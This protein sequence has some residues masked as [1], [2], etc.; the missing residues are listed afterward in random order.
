MQMSPA[1]KLKVRHDN[2]LTND[3]SVIECGSTPLLCCL[4]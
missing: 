3:W 4:A 2:L 1:L